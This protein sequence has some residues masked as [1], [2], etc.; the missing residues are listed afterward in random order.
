MPGYTCKKAAGYREEIVFGHDDDV[1]DGG[2]DDDAG[3]LK[4][5]LSIYKILN[6]CQQ[7]EHRK[8]RQMSV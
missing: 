3:P 2:D 5:K 6:A 7:L 4:T 8:L 1:D